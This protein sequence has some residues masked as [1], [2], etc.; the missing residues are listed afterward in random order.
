M[1]ALMCIVG[2][3]ALSMLLTA[4][5][6]WAR[7]DIAHV[8]LRMT[9]KGSARRSS[10]ASSKRRSVSGLVSGS[11]SQASPE[12]ATRRLPGGSP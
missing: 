10:G 7:S 11:F 3:A 5:E 8:L 6:M 2:L 4:I 9:R 12:S 1:G